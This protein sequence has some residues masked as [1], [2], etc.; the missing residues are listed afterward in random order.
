MRN[1]VRPFSL[2]LSLAWIAAWAGALWLMWRPQ[3]DARLDFTNFTALG[4]ITASGMARLVATLVG[5]VAIAL[6]LPVLLAALLPAPKR[7]DE[8]PVEDERRGRVETAAAPRMKAEMPA[9]LRSADAV[10][11]EDSKRGERSEPRLV[12]PA[13]APDD[14]ARGPVLVSEPKAGLVPPVTPAGDD[15]ASL[16][17]RLDRQEEELRRLREMVTER[18]AHPA[19]QNER[20]PVADGRA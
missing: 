17:A 7:V 15:V 3:Y 16:R 5:V 10:R 13:V 8:R 4:D 19:A 2:L 14:A 18:D 6:A 11:R 12:P 9:S 20:D 1:L